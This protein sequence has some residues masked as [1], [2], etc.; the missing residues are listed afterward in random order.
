[1]TFMLHPWWV[2]MTWSCHVPEPVWDVGDCLLSITLWGLAMLLLSC[3]EGFPLITLFDGWFCMMRFG[4]LHN[5]WALVMIG[6]CHWWTSQHDKLQ[7]SFRARKEGKGRGRTVTKV[8]K[9]AGH[10]KPG[11]IPAWGPPKELKPLLHLPRL[12]AYVELQWT[13]H[14]PIPTLSDNGAHHYLT[15]VFL[16]LPITHSL[17]KRCQ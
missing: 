8:K 15:L 1:M 13:R 5:L 6:C 7:D 16:L 3:W 9:E 12:V 17:R 14:T 2:E 11:G 10:S 4:R